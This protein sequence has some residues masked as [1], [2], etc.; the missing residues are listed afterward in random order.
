MRAC[1]NATRVPHILR[2]TAYQCVRHENQR[3]QLGSIALAPKQ[4]VDNLTHVHV[5]YGFMD[6]LAREAFEQPLREIRPEAWFLA[7]S[8]IV[9]GRSICCSARI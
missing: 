8:A 7:S 9:T 6:R 4:A 3:F 1:K 5:R 2:W